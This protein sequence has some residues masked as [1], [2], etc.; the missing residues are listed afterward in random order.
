[1]SGT[2]GRDRSKTIGSNEQLKELTQNYA[3]PFLFTSLG[4]RREVWERDW[5]SGNKTGGLG[6]R[7][8][9]WERDWR[10]G[11]KTGGLGTRLEVWEQDWRSG[12]E[13]GGLRARP[14]VW[15]QDR[16]S[17]NEIGNKTVGSGYL[18]TVWKLVW[19]KVISQ[20]YYIPDTRRRRPQSSKVNKTSTLATISW[21]N[22]VDLR[23]NNVNNAVFTCQP[24]RRSSFD[25]P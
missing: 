20:S 21:K 17:G 6:A 9:V 5:R 11:N 14:E 22:W 23:G 25:K 4:T 7:L 15:E 8:E 2:P 1:M 3:P 19:S 10:S 18:I 24:A 16:R 12:N 13:T